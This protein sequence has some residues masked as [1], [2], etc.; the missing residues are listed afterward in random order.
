[1]T[2]LTPSNPDRSKPVD[3]RAL[4]LAATRSDTVPT[5]ALFWIG[6]FAMLGA[7]LLVPDLTFAQDPTGQ[8]NQAAET[9]LKILKALFA[10]VALGCVFYWIYLAFAFFT[11]GL[12]PSLWQG[13]SSTI[14]MGVMISIGI[15]IG[16]GALFG[17][18]QTYI[19][20]FTS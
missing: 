5:T 3:S 10:F 19:K 2:I 11:Q 16:V 1:M 8:I 20:G 14:R 18:A 13:V 9:T 7:L 12:F 6:C 15:F 4:L 17:L